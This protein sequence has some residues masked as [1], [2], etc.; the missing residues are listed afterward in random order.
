MDI[1]LLQ[2]AF[3]ECNEKIKEIQNSSEPDITLWIEL[4]NLAL[5]IKDLIQA[6]YYFD[7][8]D[9]AYKDI[10]LYCVKMLD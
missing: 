1:S 4:E 7:D 3:A 9:Q 8:P 10:M 5:D 2:T 6:P